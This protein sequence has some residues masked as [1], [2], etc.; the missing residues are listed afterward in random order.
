ML[1]RDKR[2][3]VGRP[4]VGNRDAL[5]QR[6]DS[7]LDSY[8]LTNDGDYVRELE[9]KLA[10]YLNVDHCIAMCN[11][12]VALELAVR[13]M[14]M[15]GNVLVPA[16]TFIATA[17][18]LQWQQIRPVFVDIDPVSLNICP[19]SAARLIDD[20]TT[21]ILGVHLYGRPCDIDSLSRLAE[22]HDLSLVFDAAHAF[23]SSYQG[24]KIG[25]FGDCEVFSFHATKVF[26]TFEGGAVT[27]NNAELAAKLRLMRNFGFEGEDAVSYI[28]TNGKMAEINAAMGL[29]NLE[30]IDTFMEQNLQNYR[31]YAQGLQRVPGV[32]LIDYEPAELNNYQYVIV[33]IDQTRTG[34]TRDQL[35]DY[36]SEHG[37]IA[38]RY[39]YP[40]CH[41]MEP[42]RTLYPDA[43]KN[44][45]ATEAFSEVM[46]ALPTGTQIA[47]EE[48][49]QICALIRGYTRS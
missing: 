40:G 2:Y 37:V 32:R 24:K 36:L 20:Q 38:R 26:N 9:T 23:G 31:A 29:T 34:R 48:I 10:D 14:G 39:F 42:Y 18:A 28:G 1:K 27:T 3:F 30:Q 17:H 25:G 49:K 35:K 41:R 4:N 45:P 15:S 46:L 11:G 21:G 33:E 13:A 6:I 16:M 47:T 5:Y 19:K 12:T 44:L 43:G 8:W 7:I 22:K